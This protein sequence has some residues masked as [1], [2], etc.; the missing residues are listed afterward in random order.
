MAERLNDFCTGR[1]LNEAVAVVFQLLFRGTALFQIS[2]RHVP[3][4][5]YIILMIML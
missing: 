2:H 4:C 5:M 3:A 1:V